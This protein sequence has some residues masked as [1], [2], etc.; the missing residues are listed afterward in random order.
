[1]SDRFI[2]TG[3]SDF[4]LICVLSPDVTPTKLSGGPSATNGALITSLSRL[5]SN[6]TKR[7]FHL[8]TFVHILQAI[9]LHFGFGE[10][11]AYWCQFMWVI[12]I[13]SYQPSAPEYCESRKE[14]QIQ[15]FSTKISTTKNGNFA[16]TDIY[17]AFAN[18]QIINEQILLL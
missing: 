7:F 3:M 2:S 12:Y 15:Q 6:N 13:V 8:Y 9:Y 5:Y 16:K 10:N 1:M 4:F 11:V 14:I 18:Q 17:V